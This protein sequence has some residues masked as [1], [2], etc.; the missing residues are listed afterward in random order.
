MRAVELRVAMDD[1]CGV[2]TARRAAAAT[3]SGWA[4]RDD[5]ADDVCVVVSELVT[6]ALTH[7]RS[8]ALLRLVKVT[9]CCI[10]VEVVDDDTRL[11]LPMAPD[12]DSLSGRGLVLVASL[13]TLWGI[14]RGEQG[15]TVWAEFDN[16]DRRRA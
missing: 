10:R 14:E 12:Q 8:D 15:K 4:A 1:P 16:R 9:E 7:G 5:V 6:N 13:S 2:R 3:V 11:P